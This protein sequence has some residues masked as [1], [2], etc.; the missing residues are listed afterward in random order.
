M[1][2]GKTDMMLSP[3]KG[4]DSWI[5]TRV[6]FGLGWMVCGLMGNGNRFG[7]FFHSRWD[8]P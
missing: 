6:K 2:M 5:T 8:N 1:K 4:A 3:K 7:L